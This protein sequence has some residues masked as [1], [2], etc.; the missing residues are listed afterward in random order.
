M[1]SELGKYLLQNQKMCE[2]IVPLQSGSYETKNS[3]VLLPIATTIPTLVFSYLPKLV[4]I[5]LK[6]EFLQH[7]KLCWIYKI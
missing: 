1:V 2:I 4:E 3:P 6:S 5:I 7:N